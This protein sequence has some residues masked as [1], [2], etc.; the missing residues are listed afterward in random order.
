MIL[1]NILKLATI[2]VA[3]Y[4]YLDLA[5]AYFL[6]LRGQLI[7]QYRLSQPTLKFDRVEV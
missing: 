7:F 6:K 4:N 5:L 2:Q 1:W 3:I